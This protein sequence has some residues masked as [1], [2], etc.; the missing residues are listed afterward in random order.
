LAE[1]LSGIDLVMFGGVMSLSPPPGVPRLAQFAKRKHI[2]II[3][4][5]FEMVLCIIAFEIFHK[6]TYFFSF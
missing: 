3:K 1:K 4:I 2:M 5:K 6:P